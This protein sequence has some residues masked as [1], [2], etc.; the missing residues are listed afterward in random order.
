MGRLK[1][2][3]LERDIKIIPLELKAC[4]YSLHWGYRKSKAFDTNELDIHDLMEKTEDELKEKL[5]I[6]RT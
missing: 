4:L 6:K 3:K 1:G 5:L 2:Y